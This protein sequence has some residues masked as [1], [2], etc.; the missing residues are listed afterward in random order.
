[1]AFGSL[2][3][4]CCVQAAALGAVRDAEM[5]GPSASPHEHHFRWVMDVRTAHQVPAECTDAV[6]GLVPQD[7]VVESQCS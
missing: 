4:P 6:E 3:S 5:N 1:M 2:L 7:P